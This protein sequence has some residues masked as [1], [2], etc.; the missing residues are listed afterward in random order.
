ML[1]LANGI[2]QARAA[3]RD[4]LTEQELDAA[5]DAG[6]GEIDANDAAITAAIERRR[7]REQNP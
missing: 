3:G 1:E 2:R 7:Q 6:F 4:T 5:L